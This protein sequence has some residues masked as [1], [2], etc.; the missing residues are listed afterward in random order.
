V[1]QIRIASMTLRA[2]FALNLILGLIFWITGVGGVLVPIHML[3]GIAF[4]GVL[5]WIGTLQAL[6]G[7]SL[8]LQVGTFL[9]G[10]VIAIVGLFQ[11][12]WL[13]GSGHWIIQ[14]LHLLLAFLGVGLGEMSAARAKR[15]IAAKSA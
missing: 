9:L 4:V 10:L 14:V 3:I 7:G 12:R 6:R 1:Q 5:W 15:L 2:L 11:T 8:G 13:P